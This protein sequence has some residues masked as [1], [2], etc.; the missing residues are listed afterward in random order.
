[1]IEV[2]GRNHASKTKLLALSMAAE[3]MSCSP[4]HVRRLL[5]REHDP[6]PHVRLGR[7]VRIIQIDL[8]DWVIGQ[9]QV[10]PSQ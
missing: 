7:A 4:A 9:R 3:V 8:I 2:M 1:M 6:L 5:K 10:G